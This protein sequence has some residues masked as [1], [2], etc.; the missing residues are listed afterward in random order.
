MNT[1]SG[2]GEGGVSEMK[3]MFEE[4]CKNRKIKDVSFFVNRRD[5]PL[6]KKK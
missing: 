2:E 1:H 5:F 3:D 6:L 4:L